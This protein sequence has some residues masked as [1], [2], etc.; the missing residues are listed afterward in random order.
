[1]IQEKYPNWIDV[2]EQGP[3]STDLE[4]RVDI[5]YAFMDYF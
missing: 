1:L 3:I 5:E 2:H 4:G